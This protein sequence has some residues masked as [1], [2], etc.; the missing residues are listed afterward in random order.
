MKKN[1]IYIIFLTPVLAAVFPLYKHGYVF[2]LDMVWPTTLT[3][4]LHPVVTPS[5]YPLH[6]IL[7][8]LNSFLS[9]PVIQKLLL[10]FIL[11]LPGIAMY[12][13][14]SRYTGQK[15]S[16]V[17][18]LLYQLN[19]WVYERMLSGQWLVMLGYAVL[20]IFILFLTRVVEV[21]N[22]KNTI[23][24]AVM[25]AI[26]PI[27]SQHFAYIALGIAAL[28]TFVYSVIARKVNIRKFAMVACGAL[29][30][31]LAANSFWLF[32]ST[33]EGTYKNIS[34]NDFSAFVTRGD[35]VV[36][37]Y[38]NV[39]GLYGFWN[40]SYILPKDTISW[41]FS[42]TL[43][44]AILAGFGLLFYI[45]KKDPLSI[46]LLIISIGAVVFGVGYAT[47]L[48][49][50]FVVLLVKLIPGIKGLRETEKVVGLLAFVY[51]LYIPIAAQFITQRIGKRV[52]NTALGFVVILCLISVNTMFWGF[53]GQVKASDYPQSWY[54]ARSFLAHSPEHGNILLYPWHMYPNISFAGFHNVSNPAKVFFLENFIMN[55]NPD[56]AI[57]TSQT[58]WDTFTTEFVQG[59]RS[60]DDTINVLKKNKVMTIMLLKE[61]DWQRYNF[62]DQ[63][64]KI[65]KEF[66]S[67]EISIYKVK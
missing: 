14:V 10:L 13:L 16:I 39:L 4:W 26:Y 24:F 58:P 37:V 3:P 29:L 41:W 2:L 51:A 17:G 47:P 31:I 1:K 8:G 35:P 59:E 28:Y 49:T 61:A 54:E 7:I 43:L 44:F 27:L 6:L 23:Y 64:K 63:N 15:W 46:T 21:P 55:T 52:E 5:N 25:A 33:Q 57:L 42:I 18:G 22:R 50:W 48:G 40:D 11:W 12:R 34:S 53:S 30:L 62:L 20:P 67:P 65:T 19:P 32:H 66:D 9:V 38:G 56:N 36:G 60:L 45:R